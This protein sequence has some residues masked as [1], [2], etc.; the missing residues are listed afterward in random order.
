M[1]PGQ[2]VIFLAV[3]LMLW[4]LIATASSSQELEPITV[5]WEATTHRENGDELKPGELLFYRLE[6]VDE[7]GAVLEEYETTPDVLQVALNIDA[8]SCAYFYAYSAAAPGP[9]CHPDQHYTL[10]APSVRASNCSM[11]IA[12]NPPRHFE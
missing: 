11:G 10:S 4:W 7:A 8:G 5:S 6:R 12:P 3:V 9:S 2:V 1:R